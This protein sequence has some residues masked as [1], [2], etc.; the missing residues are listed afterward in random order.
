[1]PD[2]QDRPFGGGKTGTADRAFPAEH[3]Q[4]SDKTTQYNHN[5]FVIDQE[6]VDPDIVVKFSFTPVAARGF[7]GRAEIHGPQIVFRSRLSPGKESSQS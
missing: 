6:T 1:M 4:K 7:S 3:G 5:F 2:S